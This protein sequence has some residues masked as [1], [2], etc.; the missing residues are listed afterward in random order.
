MLQQ[1]RVLKVAE[2]PPAPTPLRED[3]RCRATGTAGA[4]RLLQQAYGEAA[5]EEEEAKAADCIVNM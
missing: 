3:R 4:K 5:A 2:I 1:R